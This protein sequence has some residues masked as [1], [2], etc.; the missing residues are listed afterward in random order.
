MLE[1]VCGTRQSD[2]HEF[3]IFCSVGEISIFS[4]HISYAHCNM[5]FFSEKRNDIIPLLV[6]RLQY[7]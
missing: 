5:G 7:L 3:H 4:A 2:E 1:G 6:F